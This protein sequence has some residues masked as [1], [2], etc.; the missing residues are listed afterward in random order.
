MRLSDAIEVGAQYAQIEVHTGRYWQF[1]KDFSLA[2]SKIGA[3][4]LFAAFLGVYQGGG[5]MNVIRALKSRD[6]P[7]DSACWI[8]LDGLS[9]KFRELG[10]TCS[11]AIKTAAV[12]AAKAPSPGKNE[13]LWLYICRLNDDHTWERARIV[14]LLR[15]AGN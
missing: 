15:H 12:G 11:D 1:T 3:D 2:A 8:I 10:E 9:K 4:P 6:R 7:V 13:S 5:L 14:S